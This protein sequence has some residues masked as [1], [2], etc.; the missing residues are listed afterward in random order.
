MWYF[1]RGTSASCLVIR[2]GSFSVILASSGL[3]LFRRNGMRVESPAGMRKMGRLMLIGIPRW[4]DV[5]DVHG[6]GALAKRALVARAPVDVAWLGCSVMSVSSGGVGGSRLGD[7]GVSFRT[8]RRR[9][10]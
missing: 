8:S 10:G 6:H 9:R 7:V 3:V 1:F 2:S 4:C 5:G